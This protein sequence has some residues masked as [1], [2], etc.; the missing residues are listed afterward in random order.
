[1]SAWKPEVLTKPEAIDGKPY[2]A[3]AVQ[4][5]TWE[6]VGAYASDAEA[7][8]QAQGTCDRHN[9]QAAHAKTYYRGPLGLRPEL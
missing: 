7:W 2:H 6:R 3:F 9:E 8:K 5:N 1:M 4:G